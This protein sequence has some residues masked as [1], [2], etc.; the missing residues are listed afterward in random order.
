M[1]NNKSVQVFIGKIRTQQH[2]TGIQSWNPRN[3]T[4]QC[5]EFNVEIG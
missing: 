3:K 2:T 1:M 5:S 4:A